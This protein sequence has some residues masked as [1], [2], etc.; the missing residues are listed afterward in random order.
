M[1]DTA[2][3]KPGTPAEGALQFELT[4]FSDARRALD[5]PPAGLEVARQ[6]RPPNWDSKRRPPLPTDHA[7]GGHAVDWILS[8]PVEIRPL[9]VADAIPRIANEL[10]E[11]WSDADRATA[12]VNDLL[13]ERRGGRRGFAA[14]IKKE[15]VV[16]L[17]ALRR[18]R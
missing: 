3:S 11:H 17:L 13:V 4:D 15:L 18:M 2:S 12:F 8:L 10:A 9:K 6:L 1:R 14:E 5:E 16:L 7:M